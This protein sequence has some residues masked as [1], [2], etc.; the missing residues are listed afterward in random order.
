MSRI[1]S[2]VAAAVIACP[3]LFSEPALARQPRKYQVTG[4]VLEVTKDYIAVDKSGDRWEIG[5]D[6]NTK[7]TGP[8][9]VGSKV[10]IEYQM[11][12][13]SVDVKSDRKGEP[14]AKS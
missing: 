8:L 12:A 11:T 2:L 9:K 10:T 14:K 13:A 1:M 5:R 7:V 6:A 4:T 3:L